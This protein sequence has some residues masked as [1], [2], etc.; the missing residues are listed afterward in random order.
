MSVDFLAM[1]MKEVMNP[2]KTL[3]SILKSALVMRLFTFIKTVVSS[4]L[5]IMVTGLLSK[6]LSDLSLSK[7]TFLIG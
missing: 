1:P 7:D 4:V 3:T 2:L 6:T 5:L